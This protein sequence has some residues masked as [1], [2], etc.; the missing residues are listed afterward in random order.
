MEPNAPEPALRP[1]D[2]PERIETDSL[3]LRRWE[4]DDLDA[5]YRAIAA[6]FR[7]LH[8]WMEWATEPPTG[9][10]H[11]ERFHCALRWP[12]ANVRSAAVPRRLGYRLDRIEGD[13]VKAPAESGR[14][15][16]WI[17]ER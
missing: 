1:G 9:Q 10:E 13:G 12:Q 17:K 16:V 11:R 4:P 7:H 2:V 15:M 6:S 5:R 3:V 14:G 8:P